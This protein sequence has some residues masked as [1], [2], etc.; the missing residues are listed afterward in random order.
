MLYLLGNHNAQEVTDVECTA[1]ADC[2]ELMEER[3]KDVEDMA[4]V[5]N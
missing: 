3:N 2:S 1:D 4:K 5:S